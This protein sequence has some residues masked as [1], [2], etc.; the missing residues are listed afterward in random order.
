MVGRTYQ[1][2][3][4]QN[5]KEGEKTMGGKVSQFTTQKL[6]LLKPH[7]LNYLILILS[8]SNSR[9]GL[10]VFIIYYLLWTVVRHNS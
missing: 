7:K 10:A 8:T 5:E 6:I 2:K 1:V 3:K 9:C 4:K